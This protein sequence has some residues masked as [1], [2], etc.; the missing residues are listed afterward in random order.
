MLIG[1]IEEVAHAKFIDGIKSYKARQ[2]K[3]LNELNS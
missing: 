2:V 3:S 1:G